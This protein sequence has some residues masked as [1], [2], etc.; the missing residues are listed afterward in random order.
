MNPFLFLSGKHIDRMG[1]IDFDRMGVI[2]CSEKV[3]GS[4]F[5]SVILIFWSAKQWLQPKPKADI[6]GSEERKL[7]VG[8][9]TPQSQHLKNVQKSSDAEAWSLNT[10]NEMSKCNI[11]QHVQC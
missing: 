9:F 6:Y 4:A 11:L 1:V 3:D 7:W 8:E 5:M 10:L 2:D